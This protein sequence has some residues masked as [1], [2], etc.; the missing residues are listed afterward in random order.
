MSYITDYVTENPGNSKKIGEA[1]LEYIILRKWV[2]LFALVCKLQ[3]S[4]TSFIVFSSG[5]LTTLMQLL[6]WFSIFLRL[7][8]FG[9]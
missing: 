5:D 2:T 8:W 9:G 7:I 4:I 3:L 1:R 6:F